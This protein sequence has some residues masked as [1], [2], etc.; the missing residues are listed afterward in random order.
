M[1]LEDHLDKLRAFKIILESGNMRQAAKKLNV[2][3]PSLTRLV[4]TLESA[5]CV[6][7]LY[8]G[9]LGVTPT[10]SG[11]LLLAYTNSILKSLDDLEEKIKNPTDELAG[12]LRICGHASQAEYLWPDFISAFKKKA[13]ALRLSI[14]T[15]EMFHHQKALEVGE[16][17]ILVDTEAR[18]T[19]DLISWKLYEDRF[20]FYMPK[21]NIKEWTPE[22][23]DSLTLIYC[24]TAIDGDN[25][26]ITQH[27][28]EKG[29]FFKEK[30]E[31]D[32]FTSVIAFAKKGLGLAVLPQRL[33]ENSIKSRLFQ[34]TTL[35][36]FSHKGFGVHHFTA[37]IHE[38]RK[39]DPRIRFLVRSLKDWF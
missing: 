39:D 32:S 23:I 18:I 25:K 31:L 15:S 34:R 6:S 38:S 27:L 21:S 3:Q 4:Q 35:V 29:Y 28:E 8:R 13:P 7:L 19:G 17:D 37:T 10:E 5:T 14:H 12:H 30:I 1:N 24:P 11:K 26:K 36:N 16:I 2:T 9:R 33:A 20:N 22:T